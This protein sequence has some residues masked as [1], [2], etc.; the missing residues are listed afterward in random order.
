LQGD[1]NPYHNSLHAASV[2]VDVH[3]FLRQG[4]LLLLPGMQ[5]WEVLAMVFAALVHDYRHPATSNN[6]EAATL[7]ERAMIYNDISVLENYHLSE[8]FKVTRDPAFAI[9]EG[10]EMTTYQQ[11]RGMVVE[12]VLA[13]DLK[14]HFAILAS[15]REAFGRVEKDQTFSSRMLLTLAFKAV[16]QVLCVFHTHLVFS[17]SI[18]SHTRTCTNHITQADVA[19]AAKVSSLHE[20]W[21][22]R[23]MQEFFL[24]GD[25]ERNLGLKIS[26]FM[27]SRCKQLGKCQTGFIDFLCAP[28]F[29]LL[30]QAMADHLGAQGIGAMKGLCTTKQ[31]QDL[32]KKIDEGREVDDS[33][34]QQST[35]APRTLPLCM[36]PVMVHM[37]KNR[38]MW[39][40][41]QTQEE[42]VERKRNE[43]I[44][45]NIVETQNIVE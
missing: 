27:D 7:S 25:R 24:Q 10:M 2:L 4:Q 30:A 14:Q 31:I 16:S 34:G 40:A 39:A 8:S 18:K 45:Q 12:L 23:I 29:Q 41:V 15:A 22:D 5:P 33:V 28:L 21:S 3:Y 36:A 43:N 6:F 26:P 20:A 17:S 1:K 32:V 35:W 11:M 37:R 13:T 19:H 9:F 38:A 42:E 44:A